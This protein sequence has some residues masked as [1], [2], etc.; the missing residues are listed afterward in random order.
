VLASGSGTS[1]WADAAGNAGTASN[2]FAI[3]ESTVVPTATVAS[4]GSLELNA[5]SSES[6]TF[7]GGTGSLILDQPAG[8]TGHII[9]FTGTAPDAAHSD[10]IDLVGINFSSSQFTESYNPSTGLLTVSD[11]IHNASFTFDNFNATLYFASDGKG[12]TLI[13]DPPVS[14][15]SGAAANA[16]SGGTVVA[17]PPPGHTL[18]IDSGTVLD[19]NA[20]SAD[21]VTFANGGGTN[22]SLVLQDSKAFTGV[23][24]GFTGDGTLANSDAIDIQNVNF[25]KLTIETYVENAAGTGGTLTLSDGTNTASLNFS[26]NYVSDNFKFLSD[27]GTR[28]VDPPIQTAS[29]GSADQFVFAPTA[30]PAPVQ[31]TITDFN[32]NLDTIDL[33]AFGTGVSASSLVA[34]TTAANNGQDTLVTVDSHDSILLKHV[35]AA[36]LHTSDFIIHV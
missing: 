17:H 26:G 29:I 22:G 24:T 16:P 20:A 36:N 13:T 34:S 19:I 11:G 8:F 9:G 25:A 14:G 15:V 6:V 32:V 30:G 33:R 3:S 12:G 27:G 5:A 18:T 10:T 1:P 35:H 21:G 4:G 7:A 2:I 31:H 28:V 23:I